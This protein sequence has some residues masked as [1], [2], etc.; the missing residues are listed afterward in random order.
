LQSLAFSRLV[1]AI[2]P[3]RARDTQAGLKGMTA[4][5]AARL[6]PRLRCDGF[7]LDCEILAWCERLEI[8]V[9]EVPVVVRYECHRSTTTPRSVWRMLRS[10]WAIRQN[11]AAI[12]A[13]PQDTIIPTP[14]L[15]RRAA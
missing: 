11:C 3:I 4:S 13:P 12:S 7:A 5:V 1:R 6:L 15:E 14:V 8:A 9:A 10:L 2:L